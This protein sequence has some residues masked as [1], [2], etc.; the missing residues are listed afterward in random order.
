MAERLGLEQLGGLIGVLYTSNA[1][2][3]GLGS[4]AAGLLV[5]EHGYTAAGW[6]GPCAL[7]APAVL[8]PSVWKS[9]SA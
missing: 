3:V 7:L 6:G 2:G 4:L 9:V 5:D 1:I 8:G